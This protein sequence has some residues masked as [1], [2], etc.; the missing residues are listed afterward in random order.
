VEE[1]EAAPAPG[2]PPWLADAAAAA[3][4]AS[5][6]TYAHRR[7]ARLEAA[8]ARVEAREAVAAARAAGSRA[9]WASLGR[10]GGK[11]RASRPEAAASAA[12]D[13]ADD[14]D[15]DAHGLDADF[16]ISDDEEEDPGPGKRRR[17]GGARAASPPLSDSE[18]E[19]EEEE[20]ES[21][22]E[23]GDEDGRTRGPGGAALPPDRV[24][25]AATQVVITS[26]THSQLAQFVGELNRT[27]F[28]RRGRESGE[29]GG[30]EGEGG[31]GGGGCC[32][33]AAAPPPTDPPS[34]P[35]PLSATAVALGSRAALCINDAVRA[36]GAPGRI[37]E[38]CRDLA[39][40]KTKAKGADGKQKVTTGGGCPYRAPPP[41]ARRA[42]KDAILA[43]PTD[44]EALAEAGLAVGA[45]PYYAARHLVPTA[46]VIFLPYSALLSADAR[47]ALGV[48]LRGA[49]IIIDEAH[50]LPAAVAGAYG[51]G[52]SGAALATATGALRGYLSRYG[53]RLGGATRKEVQ[54][55]LAMGD[56]L[57]RLLAGAGK[58]SGGG[59]G[60]GSGS[61]GTNPP[62][63]TSAP[64][65]PP[66]QPSALTVDAAASAAGIDNVNGFRLVASLRD[67]KVV[68][69][70]AGAATAAEARAAREAATAR[71][72]A[73]LPGRRARGGQGR[74]LPPPSAADAP[75]DAAE[76]AASSA[77]SHTA[78]L[79]ALVSFVA[80]LTTAD[81]DG[82]VIVTP[83]DRGG[84]S[85]GG[86]DTSGSLRF[87]L[88]NAGARFAAV[89]AAARA[90]VLASGTLEPSA[91]LEAQL[92]PGGLGGGGGNGEGTEGAG[93]EGAAAPAQPR[94]PPAPPPLPPSIPATRFACGH[95]LP[96]HRL[97]ALGVGAGPTGV[98]LDL[99]HGSRATPATLDE[100]GRLLLNVCAAVP[101]GVVAFFPSFAHMGAAVERWTA[102][103]ALAALARKKPGGPV[104]V[105]PRGAAA[106]AAALGAYAAA[107]LAPGGAL[108]LGVIGGKLSEGINFGDALGRGV[109]VF[110]LPYP[111]PADP[112]LVS[113]MAWLD[114]AAGPGAGRRLYTDT[115]AIAVNQTV[116]RVVRHAGD[117]AA[118]VLADARYARPGGAAARLPAWM[119]PSLRLCPAYG[120]AH[121]DLA[122]FCKAMVMEDR[123]KEK[124]KEKEVQEVE[125]GA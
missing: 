108:L 15:D 98:S 20:G 26:R 119:R 74:P 46:D 80:A 70:V 17:G 44:V 45:C 62:S 121:G 34:S 35:P 57:A 28:G 21:E 99:R 37:A 83:P 19:G 95:V 101:A 43:S 65:P 5:R 33:G 93:T 7:A 1:E 53:P 124:L 100:M 91:S 48:R 42:L 118:V 10:A 16:L 50:N 59:S 104:T 94:A 75:E 86:P 54:T 72:G 64:H 106:S 8:R 110:G 113:R 122:R 116:G 61:G 47:D 81:A 13:A 78:A 114:G 66:P 87:V 29:K 68:P 115:A 41:A 90:V 18:G 52:L 9:A 67:R 11:A 103:G 102:T 96:P 107:A 79:H 60:S 77:P 69:K 89:L 27:R 97:L 49:V 22:P 32:G 3:A 4:V 73:V 105:E 2:L 36:L 12:A 30:E 117:W 55:L 6:A 76:L 71:G 56:G 112:E 58:G 85:G 39:S 109:L 24:R 38:K 92:F 40:A 88:L 31:N 63:T 123:E 111:N 23:S 25:A 51:A 125:G 14:G 120:T 84:S 82:R